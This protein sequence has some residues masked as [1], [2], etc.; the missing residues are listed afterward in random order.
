MAHLARSNTPVF[1]GLVDGYPNLRVRGTLKDGAV[2]L[3]G[4]FPIIYEGTEIECFFIRMAVPYDFPKSLPR[5]WETQGRIPHTPERHVNRTDGTLCV[6][7]PDEAYLGEVSITTVVNYLDGPLRN[8]FIG[9]LCFERGEAWPW[10][11]HR[12]GE[13][14]IFDFYSKL[15]GADNPVVVLRVLVQVYEGRY[16]GHWWCPCGSG[17]IIRK[18]HGSLM[19]R[20]REKIPERLL[21][22]TIVA[23][24]KR[25]DAPLISNDAARR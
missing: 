14:G 16:K 24:G 1:I 23:I 18:C 6:M 25:L 11:E 9:Q 19:R 8:Y 12:H 10:G 21:E 4:K 3:Q 15:V 7:F 22:R 5:V 20:I 13:D 2:V 17:E